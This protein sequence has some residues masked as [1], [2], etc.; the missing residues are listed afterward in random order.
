MK[1]VD[2]VLNKPWVPGARGP[3]SFDCY[4]LLWWVKKHFYFEDIP[5]LGDIPYAGL[6]DVAKHFEENFAGWDHLDKPED[7]C[8]VALSM[9]RNAIHHCGVWTERDGGLV[10]HADECGQVK[11]QSVRGLRL[12]GWRTIEFYQYRKSS[13]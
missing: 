3:D 8:A 11:A 6:K 7:G 4:G 12:F 5:H 2:E 9:I 13:G 10:I 1:W